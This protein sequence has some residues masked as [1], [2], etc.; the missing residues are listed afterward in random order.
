MLVIFFVLALIAGWLTWT[1][2]GIAAA[3][4]GHAVTR[5]AFFVC[6]GHAGQIEVAGYEPEELAG[7]DLPPKGWSVVDEHG[8]RRWVEAGPDV[9]G[10]AVLQPGMALADARSGTM[11]R[12]EI[13]SRSE[14]RAG[15][16][17][18]GI[19]R[20]RSNL[21]WEG[22]ERRGGDGDAGAEHGR[23]ARSEG[24]PQTES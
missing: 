2:G 1:T 13:G 5:F 22:P 16:L 4:I 21:P 15:A 18:S 20:R 24:W 23:R 19:E 11:T 8:R 3:F 9:A 14:G 12:G 7:Q 10:D 17:W 6:T